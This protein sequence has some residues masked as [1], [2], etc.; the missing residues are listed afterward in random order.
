MIAKGLLA[1]L[2]GG[3]AGSAAKLI[4]EAIYPPR[5]LGQEAP[6]AL[7]VEKILGQPLS[8]SQQTLASQGFHWTFG[9]GLGAAYGVAAE[10]V[11]QVTALYGV[12]FGWAVLVGTHESV[13]PVLGLVEPPLQQPLQEQTSEIATHALY[14]FV[15]ELVRRF[16]MRYWRRKAAEAVA[17]SAAGDAAAS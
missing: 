15:T 8:K 4:G 9:P 6:P 13:L 16:L 14:G 2:I 1:G 3:V 10:F 11:P 12:A 5:T 17:D 7:F